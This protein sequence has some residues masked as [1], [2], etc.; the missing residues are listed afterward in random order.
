M[1]F[2]IIIFK[3][4]SFP[5]RSFFIWKFERNYTK[6]TVE[7]KPMLTKVS[8]SE[9]GPVLAFFSGSIFI[10]QFCNRGK[11]RKIFVPVSSRTVFR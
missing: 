5:E 9:T 10:K 3:P 6:G 8:I 2:L 4:V 1:T 7:N 11:T